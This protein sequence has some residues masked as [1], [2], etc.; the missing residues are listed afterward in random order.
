MTPEPTHWQLIASFLGFLVIVQG[1]AVT[2]VLFSVGHLAKGK[3][4]LE[5][6]REHT[7]TN[8]QRFSETFEF[9]EKAFNGQKDLI[10]RLTKVEERNQAFEKQL[11]KVQGAVERIEV[12]ITEIGASGAVAAI[13]SF[14]K[15][16]AAQMK[17]NQEQLMGRANLRSSILQGEDL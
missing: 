6:F 15:E 16:M 13:A 1:L 11:G 8:K 9:C 10:E 14:Q 3:V 12:K 4:E 7:E 17:V 5:T 2:I